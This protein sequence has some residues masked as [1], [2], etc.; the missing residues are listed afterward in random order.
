MEKVIFPQKSEWGDTLAAHSGGT[1]LQ[2]VESC[3]EAYFH[4]NPITR[5]LFRQRLRKA[6][7]YFTRDSYDAVL[8]AGCGIGFLLPSLALRAKKVSGI[9]HFETAIQ[10]AEHLVHQRGLPSVSLQVADMTKLPF[11]DGEFDAVV[12]LSVLEHIRDLDGALKELARV[13]RKD[14]TIVLGFPMEGKG[15]L[16]SFFEMI[17][18]YTF[19]WR[20]SRILHKQPE[21]REQAPGHVSTW[22][23]IDSAIA[24]HFYIHDVSFI[25]FFPI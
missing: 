1:Y 18:Y 16:F 3:S 24:R 5:Y 23:E 17:D 15:S 11:S 25:S 19:S 13:S 20:Y 2:L 8:D 14:A 12:S 9:D 4:K 6:M 21:L 7:S 10:C 22:H